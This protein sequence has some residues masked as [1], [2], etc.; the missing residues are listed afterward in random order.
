MQN[1]LAQIGTGEG[2]S[3]IL[4]GLACFLALVGF[5]VKCACYSPYLSN[6]D[7]LSFNNLFSRLGIQKQIKYGT[8]NEI[9]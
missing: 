3:I 6:R 2:K 1:R 8:F 5:K 4:A 9:C 7:Q